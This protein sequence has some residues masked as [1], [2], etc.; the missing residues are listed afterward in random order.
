M[1]LFEALAGRLTTENVQKQNLW[2]YGIMQFML[3]LETLWKPFGKA[4]G[5][6]LEIILKPGFTQIAMFDKACF[7]ME[8]HIYSML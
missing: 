5:N 2:I 7:C 6:P 8:G 1:A 3:E 4:F